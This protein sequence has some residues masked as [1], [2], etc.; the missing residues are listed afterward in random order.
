M[1]RIRSE[2]SGP[3][4]ASRTRIHGQDARRK[5]WVRLEGEGFA[6]TLPEFTRTKPPGFLEI[7]NITG[8]DLRQA[9][10]LHAV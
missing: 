3:D 8:V 2:I 5:T 1:G 7:M 9:R 6:V 4:H 10:I